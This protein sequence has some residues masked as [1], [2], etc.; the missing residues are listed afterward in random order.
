M[1]DVPVPPR[2]APSGVAVVASS[3]AGVLVV[4]E[5]RDPAARPFAWLPTD[6]EPVWTHVG[7]T[8]LLGTKLVMGSEGD[9]LRTHD[10]LTGETEVRTMPEGTQ[11]VSVGTAGVVVSSR[12]EHTDGVE[13]SVVRPDGSV[14]P[15]TGLSYGVDYLGG[16]PTHDDVVVAS[17][18]DRAAG[19]RRYHLLDTRTAHAVTIDTDLRVLTTSVVQDGDQLAWWSHDDGR[20][21]APDDDTFHV[22]VTTLTDGVPGEIRYSEAFPRDGYA[23]PAIVLADGEVLLSGSAYVPERSKGTLQLRPPVTL[24]RVTDDGAV[25]PVAETQPVLAGP[26]GGLLTSDGAHVVALPAT[27]QDPGADSVPVWSAPHDQLAPQAVALDG[28]RLLVA[29]ADV[30]WWDPD[31][32]EAPAPTP[33]GV[34]ADTAGT[35]LRVHRGGALVSGDRFGSS[36]TAALPGHAAPGGIAGV[37]VPTG[38]LSGDRILIPG[39]YLDDLA[40]G[41]GLRTAPE[42]A[43]HD[44]VLWRRA[45]ELLAGRFVYPE[46]LPGLLVGRSLDDGATRTLRPSAGCQ[47]ERQRAMQAAG[48]WLLVPCRQ[49]AEVLDVMGEVP[50]Q[51]VEWNDD[52]RL[53]NGALLRTVESQE[54]RVLQWRALGAGAESWQDLGP[55]RTTRE[56]EVAWQTVAVSSWGP[57]VAAA[58]I[59]PEGRVH[60]AALPATAVD[61]TP[62]TGPSTAPPPAT[63]VAVSYPDDG[64]VTVTW[65]HPGATGLLGHFVR[66]RSRNGTTYGPLRLLP[67]DA[68]SLRVDRVHLDEYTVEVEPA[69]PAGRAPAATASVRP[70]LV[71]PAPPSDFHVDWPGLAGRTTQ[72]LWTQATGERPTPTAHEVWVD[73]ELVATYPYSSTVYDTRSDRTS[74]ITTI[75]TPTAGQYRVRVVAR[76]GDWAESTPTST[77]RLPGPDLVPPRVTG[78]S[79]PAAAT[80][81][82]VRYAFTGADDRWRFEGFQVRV[83]SARARQPLGAWTYP[84]PW[85][86]LPHTATGVTVALAEG[87]TRCVQVRVKDLD[88]NRSAWSVERCT[89]R[90]VDDRH[91]VAAGTHARQ[92]PST[93]MMRTVTRLDRRGSHVRLS[94]NR[95]DAVWLVATRC[96]TCGV[97]EVMNDGVVLARVDLR[98]PSTRAQQVVRVPL[99]RAHRSGTFAVRSASDRPAHI[100]G[101]VLRSY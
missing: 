36:L 43:L 23:L 61:P 7:G 60:H 48:R 6:G 51:P 12:S 74:H 66:L 52:F 26:T 97:V 71:R 94:A 5:S 22:S 95:T 41:T 78:T 57:D 3:E 73:D 49:G 20:W 63:D 2:A 44:G 10:L 89:T 13:V 35:D 8:D 84:T 62:P 15:A 55:V 92:T 21:Q 18:W 99:G 64:A 19:V 16:R 79:L 90:A 17:S 81:T 30:R 83:R 53:G 82:S 80:G 72:V 32:L 69:G 76:L 27:T 56:G 4:R 54:G 65:E 25:E 14:V 88:G 11:W 46:L 34:L 47:V 45:D 50:P 75:S 98:S 9:T 42:A 59:T 39:G 68:R 93:A 86:A 70:R 101:L 58:W 33:S 67:P 77:T 29:A 91:L 38:T 28:A 87:E 96:P 31:A 85:A 100:D 24:Q 1:T 40:T 37:P